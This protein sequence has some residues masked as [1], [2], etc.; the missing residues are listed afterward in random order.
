MTTMWLI[1]G[2]A[3]GVCASACLGIGFAAGWLR[4]GREERK[5][6]AE[7]AVSLHAVSD[8]VVKTADG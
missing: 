6:W 8:E 5:R 2:G 4:R 3:A 7:A 1:A